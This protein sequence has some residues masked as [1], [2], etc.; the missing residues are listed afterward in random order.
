MIPLLSEFSKFRE[1]PVS[2]TLLA[3]YLQFSGP[4]QPM[5][6]P[7]LFDFS[8]LLWKDGIGYHIINNHLLINAKRECFEKYVRILTVGNIS[9]KV[10]CMIFA[11]FLCCSL[12]FC[13][14]FDPAPSPAAS[15][16]AKEII[17][18]KAI[19]TNCP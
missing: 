9:T 3:L 15:I 4:N 10:R 5:A 2:T 18:I 12:T 11:V 8:E 19:G 7:I 13:S 1:G 14:F 17:V 6:I 16:M